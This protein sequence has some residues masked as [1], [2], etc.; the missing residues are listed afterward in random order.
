[1]RRLR[2]VADVLSA[3]TEA[4]ASALLIFVALLGLA[5]FALRGLVRGGIPEAS[6]AAAIAVVVIAFLGMARGFFE[7]GHVRLSMIERRLPALAAERLQ[8][9]VKMLS[10][11]TLL[12]LT[13][14]GIAGTLAFAKR[15]LTA[16]SMPW[17]PFWIP[18]LA[19]PVGAA[20]GFTALL[21]ARR[22]AALEEPE[23]E[24]L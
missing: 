22:E 23:A 18:E 6:E 7:H 21:A 9:G 12:L 5:N 17:L 10:L 8:L 2:S 15:T 13:V 14:Y 11:L 1:M 4:T 16:I 24:P 3:L 20:I 19:I